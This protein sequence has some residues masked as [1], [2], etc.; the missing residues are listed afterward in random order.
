MLTHIPNVLS[1][2]QLKTL[3]GFLDIADFSNGGN[4]APMAAAKGVKNNLQL[5]IEHENGI[6]AA[7]YLKNILL[8]NKRF[9]KLSFAKKIPPFMF[10]YYGEGMAYGPHF[11]AATMMLGTDK[12]QIRTDISV[13]VFLNN[14][15]EY[16]GGE[17]CIETDF[18]VST[19]KG[20]AGDLVLYPSTMLHEVKK[21]TKGHR[22]AAVGWIQSFLSDEKKRKI[23][24]HLNNVSEALLVENHKQHV[25]LKKA[26]ALLT[27]M[28][29][30][31]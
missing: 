20:N 28:W 9:I 27:R 4:T 14:P 17:L 24:L 25:N 18:G 3:H 23:L 29:I 12:A 19:V 30:E 8:K 1:Q 2:E 21:I 26:Q 5:T 10:S 22:L 7:S 31:V 15:N 16:E 6:K 11:D 13:T